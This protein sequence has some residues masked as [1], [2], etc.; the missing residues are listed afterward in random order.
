MADM[1]FFGADMQF[2]GADMQFFLLDYFRPINDGFILCL[3]CMQMRE[4][5]A[6]SMPR[7]SNE[8]NPSTEHV[9]WV[10]SDI[11]IDNLTL[12][13]S[14]FVLKL[15]HR[16]DGVTVK[17]KAKRKVSLSVIDHDKK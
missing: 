6:L 7:H 11:L 13:D 9:H 16:L 1:Q 14:T 3:H 5:P 12:H 17:C 10:K 4:T 8:G 15:R 2:F